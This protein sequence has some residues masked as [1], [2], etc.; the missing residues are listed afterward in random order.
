MVVR[1]QGFGDFAVLVALI[2]ARVQYGKF[3][4]A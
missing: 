3:C 2:S 1:G 4:V